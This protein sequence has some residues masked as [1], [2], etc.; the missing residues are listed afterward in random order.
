[1]VLGSFDAIVAYFVFV[2]VAFL[3]LTVAGLFVLSRR[4]GVP[5][6]ATPLFPLLPAFFIACILVVL[7]LLAAGR[8]VEAGLGV[9]AVALGWPIYRLGARPVDDEPDRE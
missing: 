7:A 1:V 2:T 5:A 4:S 9:A 3:G 8:P 6:V